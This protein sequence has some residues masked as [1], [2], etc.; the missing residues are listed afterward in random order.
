M[1]DLMKMLLDAQRRQQVTAHQWIASIFIALALSVV[2]LL[3]SISM[4]IGLF[5]TLG[6]IGIIFFGIT[7]IVSV[8]MH[9]R[10]YDGDGGDW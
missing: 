9:F 5:V 2:V 4:G 6:V 8:I 7:L 10:R 3:I 1:D